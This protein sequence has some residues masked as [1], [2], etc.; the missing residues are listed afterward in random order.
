[1][2]AM[3]Q[4]KKDLVKNTVFRNKPYEMMDFSKLSNE[5]KHRQGGM[6]YLNNFHFFNEHVAV[7]IREES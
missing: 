2:K 7:Q 6:S 5:A 4:K 1:M 3:K